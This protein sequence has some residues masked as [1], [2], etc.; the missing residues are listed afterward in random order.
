MTG[1]RLTVGG[2]VD[3]VKVQSVLHS[4]QSRHLERFALK[5]ESLY[6]LK[7]LKFELSSDYS[8]D[9]VCRKAVLELGE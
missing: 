2:R 7:V 1:C 8:F 4:L 9:D 6:S 3:F 5:E